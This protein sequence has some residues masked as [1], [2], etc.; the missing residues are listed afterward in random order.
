[1]GLLHLEP[2]PRRASKADLLA[3]LDRVGGLD[4]SRVGKIELHGS[5]AA[6]EVPDGWESRLARTLDGQP[7]G[8]RRIRA[9]AGDA[10]ASRA[11]DEDHFQRLAR[12]LELES[13]AAAQQAA[14]SAKRFSGAD[15]ERTGNSLVDLAVADEDTGLGGRY[16]VQLVKRRRSPLPWTRLDVGSPVHLSPEAARKVSTGWRGVVYQR[17]EL[18]IRV[19]LPGVPDEMGD[20]EAWRLDLSSDE[21]AAGRQQLALQRARSA[22]GERLAELRDVLL[23]EREPRFGKEADEPALDLTLNDTQQAAVR[24]ALAAQRRGPDSRAARHRQDDGGGRA[25]PAGHPARRKGTGLRPEQSGR[26]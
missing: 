3:L 6:I 22:A 9:W 25:D 26:R 18:S 17:D 15:A 1:M 10:S 11:G 4:R 23:G 16:L 24:F 2:L 14:E 13:Q 5:R 21:V 7:L 20:Y 12:L 19:A 8:E